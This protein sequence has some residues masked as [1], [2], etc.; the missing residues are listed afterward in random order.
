MKSFKLHVFI[1]VPPF[2]HY[3][4][5]IVKIK[6]AAT[7]LVA[8]FSGEDEGSIPMKKKEQSPLP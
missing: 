3:I 6:K 5:N 7:L 8:A 1:V 2:Y 4:F